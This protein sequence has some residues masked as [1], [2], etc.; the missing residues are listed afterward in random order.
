MIFAPPKTS[1]GGNHNRRATYG[2][3]TPNGAGDDGLL[4]FPRECVKMMS[5]SE[6]G[7]GRGSHRHACGFPHGR[8]A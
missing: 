7:I 6:R 4:F 1:E 8:T 3:R 5:G 2:S